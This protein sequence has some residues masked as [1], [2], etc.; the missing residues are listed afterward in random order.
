[1]LDRR[2]VQRVADSRQQRLAFAPVVAEDADLDQL[3]RGERVVDLA[4]HC[5]RESML[6][7]AGDRVQVVR[8]GA[9]GAAFGGC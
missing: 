2:G 8:F 9:E 3:M 1:M 6:A 5:R 4:Q 7:D